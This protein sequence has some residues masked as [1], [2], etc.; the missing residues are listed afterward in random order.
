M[1]FF[2]LLFMGLAL[3]LVYFQLFKSN[4]IAKNENN[5]RLWINE[6]SIDRGDIYDR[7]DNLLAYDEE[8]SDGTK[9]RIYNYGAVSSTVTGYNSKTYGKTGLEKTF[10]KLLLN[11]HDENLSQFRKMIVNNDKG[12]DLHLTFCL[13]YTSDA[14]DE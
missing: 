1:I 2:V 11:L 6:D 7:N 8:N 9:T 12:N 3:Y 5:R 13:L 10:N 4:E 14:A